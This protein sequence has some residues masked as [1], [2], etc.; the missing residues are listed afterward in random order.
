MNMR[1]TFPSLGF[2]R[3]LKL[4]IN[5]HE[6]AWQPH[7]LLKKSSS[8]FPPP[9]LE[10]W[11]SG[12]KCFANT[13]FAQSIV[14]LPWGEL[15]CTALHTE[16]CSNRSGMHWSLHSS[17]CT[18]HTVLCNAHCTCFIALAPCTLYFAMYIAHRCQWTLQI[19]S[20]RPIMEQ[21][22]FIGGRTW[23]F[24]ENKRQIEEEG[25]LQLS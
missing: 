1:G 5:Q 14:F 23:I 7:F 21:K 8:H 25:F 10:E 16:W 15:H 13:M 22:C 4:K 12:G 9:F 6:D 11:E 20:L 3:F 18:V 17:N 24:V 19:P 2:S